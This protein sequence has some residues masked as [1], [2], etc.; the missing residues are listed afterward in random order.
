MLA[1]VQVVV[2]AFER[3]EGGVRAPLQDQSTLDHQDLIGPADGRKPVG[4]HKRGAPLH[5]VAK[6][7]LNH[8]L[9]FGVERR[10]R[11]IEDKDARVG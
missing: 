10:G 11:F 9:R 2:T 6:A 1:G 7:I 4:D 5:Q 8:G 3:I